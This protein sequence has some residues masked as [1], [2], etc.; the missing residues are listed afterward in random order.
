MKQLLRLLRDVSGA[1]ALEMALAFPVLVVIVSAVV[2]AGTYF[3][4]SADIRHALGEGVRFATLCVQTKEGCIPPSDDEI[5]AKMEQSLFGRSKASYS[6]ADPVDG[7]GYREL[8]IT[9]SQQLSFVLFEGPVVTSTQSK[10][11]YI[12]S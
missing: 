11:A 8:G 4:A 7:P 2:Q 3:H 5:K 6:I 1:A 10:R 9:Y 12:V